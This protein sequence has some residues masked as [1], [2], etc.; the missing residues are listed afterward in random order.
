MH[1][2]G[3]RRYPYHTKKVVQGFLDTVHRVRITKSRQRTNVCDMPVSHSTCF[4]V[5]RSP[6]QRA[7]HTALGTHSLQTD[8]DGRV[9]TIFQ[10]GHL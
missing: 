10:I 4:T 2:V 8:D 9:D 7:Q 3:A 6:A 5:V 1:N